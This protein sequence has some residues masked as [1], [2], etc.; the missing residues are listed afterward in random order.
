MIDIDLK[1]EWGGIEEGIKRQVYNFN[2]AGLHTSS[3][4]E[5]HIDRGGPSPYV[6][7]VADNEPDNDSP[8][9]GTW[10][11]EI[12]RTRELVSLKIREFYSD[13]NTSP[14]LRVAT[15]QGKVGFWIICNEEEFSKWR[16]EVDEL[17][18][19][20]EKGESYS[21]I[22]I[23]EGEKEDRAQRLLLYRKE[24]DDFSEFLKERGIW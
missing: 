20:K 3:S 1:D 6:Y 14:D 8:E 11:K 16:E 2:L 21:K 10:K 22:I 19:K 7:V 23:S 12:E 9:F 24:M 15:K 18:S 5:G 17:V 4:C 13:R